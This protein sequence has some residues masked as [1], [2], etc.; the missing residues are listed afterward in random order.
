MGPFS[1]RF[2]RSR[3]VKKIFG[4]ETNGTA[5]GFGI[6]SGV[7]TVMLSSFL[8]AKRNFIHRDADP[9]VRKNTAD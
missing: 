4:G 9:D 5:N 2:K 6:F 3:L 7:V 8:P 1:K